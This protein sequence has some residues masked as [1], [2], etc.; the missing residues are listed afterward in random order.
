[1]KDT[2]KTPIND[3]VRLEI[4]LKVINLEKKFWS[5]IYLTLLLHS[6]EL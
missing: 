2:I 5:E 1:M 3:K 6:H 4:S